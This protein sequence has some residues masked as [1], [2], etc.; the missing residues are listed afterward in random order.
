MMRRQTHHQSWMADKIT[1]K[2]VPYSLNTV[3]QK[4]DKNYLQSISVHSIQ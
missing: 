1:E 4:T 2:V 3:H